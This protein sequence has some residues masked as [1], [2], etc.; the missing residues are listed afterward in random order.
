MSTDRMRRL[1]SHDSITSVWKC[2]VRISHRCEDDKKSF[3]LVD[4]VSCVWGSSFPTPTIIW[5]VSAAFFQYLSFIYT[6]LPLLHSCNKLPSPCSS[7]CPASWRTA[8]FP[9]SL[10]GTS[11]TARSGP[12]TRT[13]RVV[14][15]WTRRRW[16][17][18]SNDNAQ[19][20]Q[21]SRYSLLR[22]LWRFVVT[23]KP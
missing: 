22:T 15:Y 14:G 23:I 12:S 20:T 9:L 3:L 17:I 4:G 1:G 16:A 11:R 8:T 10:W 7:T 6:T 19:N 2:L 18:F 21:N 5:S 13:S